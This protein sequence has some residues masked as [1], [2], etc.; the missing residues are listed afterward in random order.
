MFVPDIFSVVLGHWL[1]QKGGFQQDD[2]ITEYEHAQS[3]KWKI[4]TKT[5]RSGLPNVYD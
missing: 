2:R 1:L 4:L 5:E 3:Q